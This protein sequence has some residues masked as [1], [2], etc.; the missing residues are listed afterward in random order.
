MES[1]VAS[2]EEAPPTNPKKKDLTKN[3]HLEAVSMLVMMATEDHLKRGS[4]MAVTRRLNMACSTIY[5]LWEQAVCTCAM[6]IIDS[7]ELVPWK[8]FW[9]ST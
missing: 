3:E 4:V 7:P 2:D 1:V 8:K 6:G 5:R 9:E